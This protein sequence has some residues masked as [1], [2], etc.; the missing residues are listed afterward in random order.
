MTESLTFK[1]LNINSNILKSLDEMGFENP[2]EIQEKAI[3]M[4]ARTTK[5]FVGQAQTGTGKTAAFVIPLLEKIDF[6]N[7]NVQALILAP[8]RELANQVEKEIH[9]LGKFTPVRST[10]VY[11]GTSYDK[12][13]YA[14]KREM[15]HIVVGT[16]G[17]VIDMI[18]RRVLKLEHAD[19][20]VL[21]EADEMLN[22]GFFEDIQII[23]NTFKETRQLVMF[24]ATM[25]AAILKLIGNSFRDYNMVKIERQSLSNDDIEQKYF[26]VR[27]KHHK[28]ALA[29]LIDNAEEDVYGIVFCRTKIETREVGDELKNRGYSVEVL[30][31]DMGQA[32]RD[33]AMRNFKERKVNIMVCT[34]VA[35]RGIDVTNLTHVFNFGLPQDDESYVH[36]IGRT[37]RAGMKGRAYTIIGPK[38]A[39]A[40]KKIERHINKRIEMAKLPTVIELKKK[41]VKQELV[42]A[43]QIF[44]AIQVKG[45]GFKTDESFDMF[46][47]QFG[48][49]SSDELL[50][51][52]FTWKFNKIIRHYNNLEDI[53][54]TV[55]TGG[56]DNGRGGSSRN[57]RNRN[58][59][60]GRSSAGGG[61]GNFDRGRSRR[62]ASDQG[63]SS[64]NRR[65]GRSASRSAG[66]SP[67]GE[68]RGGN[69]KKNSSP[70]T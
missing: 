58:G 31:G 22:M 32:E 59:G 3:P 39:F 11:G 65:S 1:Q 47:S 2:T 4:L 44:D 7:D 56:R 50:K 53:E 64:D 34:D 40:M 63:G 15:P 48:D 41:V 6:S 45:E 10:C 49:L 33:F 28:E 5:D 23:L 57:N 8:T 69:F 54:Q 17:R 68:S 27:D 30:N 61:R 52:M 19:F 25:P 24:S 42:S 37:G 26:V 9:K 51:L 66:R 43:K 12:Q 70:R 46:K 13:I 14:L 62:S 16:P 18:N 36:R 38:K 35:A 20:C 55:E 60:A 67:E 21:D 29:R